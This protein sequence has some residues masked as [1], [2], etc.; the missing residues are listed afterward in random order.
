MPFV[1]RSSRR[2]Q[3]PNFVKERN[4]CFKVASSASQALEGATT[5]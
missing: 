5:V 4:A 3:L 2:L 1:R